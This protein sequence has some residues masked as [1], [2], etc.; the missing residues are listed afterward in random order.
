ME[1]ITF[2]D[3]CAGIGGFRLGLQSLGWRCIFTCE[4]D[5][6]CESTYK[7]NF[8]DRFDAHDVTTIEPRTF[9]YCDVLCAG[10]PCQPFSIAGKQLGFSDERSSV[11]PAI[12]RITRSALPKVLVLENVSN[13]IRH[14]GGRTF[15]QMLSEVKD[16]G[17]DVHYE[18]LN[19]AFFGVPQSRPRVFIIAFRR[20]LAAR[21]FKIISK[22]TNVTPFRPY[23]AHGDYSIPISSK[24]EEYIDLYSGSK[25]V[26]QMSFNVP[27]TRTKLER[28]NPG[29]ILSDCIFQMRSSGIRALSL[30]SPLPTLAVSHSGGGAMIPVYSKERRHLSVLEMKRVM[31]FPDEFRFAGARTF[32]VKQLANAVCPPVVTSL[33][34][35]VQEVLSG[36]GAHTFDPQYSLPLAI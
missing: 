29:A 33:G 6:E 2:A 11:F 21:R 20:D 36:N 22:V 30:D 24:W 12:M 1:Q 23:I 25:S 4:I 7:A 35:Q 5:R 26:D 10:F 14:D 28:I 17:Y 3:I 15:A 13:L 8:N 9:P 19:S 32:A 16:I 34:R 27:K 18:V 31:G